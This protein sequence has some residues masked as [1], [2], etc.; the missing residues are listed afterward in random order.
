VFAV[1]PRVVS[2]WW[3]Q[4]G[5]RR[6]GH[7]SLAMLLAGRTTRFRSNAL[8]PRGTQTIHV[9]CCLPMTWLQASRPRASP[10]V[11]LRCLRGCKHLP[12]HLQTGAAAQQVCRPVS[13]LAHHCARRHPVAHEQGGLLALTV[14]VSRT[15]TAQQLPTLPQVVHVCACRSVL[16]PPARWGC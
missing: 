1:V 13:C 4:H 3:W 7:P 10:G 16:Q 14:F 15:P 12:L 11:L 2:S 9:L 8:A 5:A 6:A